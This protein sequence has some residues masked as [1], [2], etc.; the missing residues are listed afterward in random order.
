MATAKKADIN[1]YIGPKGSGKSYLSL[2][3][4]RK[5][6]RVIRIDLNNQKDFEKG[7][8]VI[9]T[10]TD[11]SAF[12]KSKQPAKRFAVC[13][14]PMR[15]YGPE[16]GF[17]IAAT[18]AILAKNV[19]ILGDETQRFIGKNSKPSFAAQTLIGQGRHNGTPFYMTGFNPM[20][21]NLEARENADNIHIFGSTK[22]PY[23]NF[24]KDCGADRE[25]IEMFASGQVPKYAYALVQQGKKP[26]LIKK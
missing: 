25:L 26:I 11:L 22:A 23:R 3:H 4:S 16:Q 24:L 12:I 10:A 19:G 5:I 6:S 18:A 13:W 15:R 14:R 1:I 17:E 21:I 9:E 8:E 20:A 2:K 7:A